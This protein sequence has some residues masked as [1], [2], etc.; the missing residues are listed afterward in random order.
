MRSLEYAHYRRLVRHFTNRLFESDMIARGGNL[1]EIVVTIIALLIAGG[2]VLAYVTALQ[3]ARHPGMNRAMLEALRW[4]NREFL[5]SLSMA[6]TAALSI[7]S[8]ESVF[9]DRAD[10]VILS[11]MPLRIRTLLAAKLTTLLAAFAITVAATNAATGILFPLLTASEGSLAITFVAHFVSVLAASAFVFFSFLALQAVLIHLLP[12]RYWKRI[13]AW[14]QL[15]ALFTV[16]F[17]FFLVPPISAPGLLTQPAN[18]RIVALVPSFWFVGLYQTILGTNDPVVHWLARRACLGL[19]VCISIALVGYLAGYRRHVRKTIEEAGS[20]S[21]IRKAGLSWTKRLLDQLL[22]RDPH[23]RAVFWFGWRTMVR[24]RMP[25]LMLA[26]YASIGL[27]YLIDGL[28]SALKR[29]GGHVLEHPNAALSAFPLILPFF[30]LLGMRVLFT[31][32]VE[33]GSNWLFRF[34]D[35][36][37]P[38]PSLRAARKLMAITGIVPVCVAAVPM[39]VFLWGWRLGVSHVL[40]SLLLALTVLQMLTTGFYKIPFTCTFMPGKANLKVMFIIYAVVF[41]ILAFAIV[42]LELWALS[43]TARTLKAAVFAA[44]V[45]LWAIWRR[46]REESGITAQLVYEERANWQL[47]TIELT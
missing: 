45:L 28:S 38:K 34:A 27:V 6:A 41:L 35:E 43:D 47:N 16:L 42:Q 25:R 10:C 14:I 44:A 23:E 21:D 3:F 31:F 1:N 4:E 33:L 46:R 22:L 20:I 30:L 8:W 39:Y 26:A 24:N 19:T 13:S 5:L 37:D 12:Y 15:G 9:P 17:G 2:V 40:L 32:P 18:H 7:V 11:Q 29:S 36:G